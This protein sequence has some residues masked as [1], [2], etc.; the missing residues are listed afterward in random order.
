MPKF[1]TITREDG[2]TEMYSLIE[3]NDPVDLAGNRD[4]QD[5]ANAAREQNI[6]LRDPS[7]YDELNEWFKVHRDM[8]FTHNTMLEAVEVYDEWQALKSA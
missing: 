2:T 5:A 1:H 4:F 8:T 3:A 7:R 6:D